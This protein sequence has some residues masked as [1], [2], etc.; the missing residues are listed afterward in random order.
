MSSYLFF[1]ILC[2]F[3]SCLNFENDK[4]DNLLLTLIKYLLAK[5]NGRRMKNGVL[6]TNYWALQMRWWSMENGMMVHG[7]RADED[8]KYFDGG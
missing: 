7:K 6:E 5:M 3:F 4:F 8:G 1:Y 2:Y